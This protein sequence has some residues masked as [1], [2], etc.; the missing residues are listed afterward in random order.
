MFYQ[1]FDVFITIVISVVQYLSLIEIY[2]NN[3]QLSIN[4][5][6]CEV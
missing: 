6:S 2:V 4:F 5:K 1:R 3:N